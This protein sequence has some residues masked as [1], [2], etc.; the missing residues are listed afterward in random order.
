MGSEAAAARVRIAGTARTPRARRS[1]RLASKAAFVLFF[2][3]RLGVT[4]PF[5]KRW[6]HT[7]DNCTTYNNSILDPT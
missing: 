4:K 5:S 1:Q 7:L 6:H 3:V 2:A